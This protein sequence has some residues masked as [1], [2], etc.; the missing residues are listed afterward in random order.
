M[1]TGKGEEIN[2]HNVPV[3][4]CIFY[5]V[6]LQLL[7]EPQAWPCARC[8]VERWN[9]SGLVSTLRMCFLVKMRLH[10]S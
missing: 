2:Q 9:K 7:A 1:F 4:I 5:L 8:R 10:R 6:M 3:I